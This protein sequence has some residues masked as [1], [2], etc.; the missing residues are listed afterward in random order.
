M[1]SVEITGWKVG[2]KKVACTQIVRAATGLGLADGKRVTD[3]V[4]DGEIQRI[5]V[6]SLED[7]NQLAKALIEIGAIASVSTTADDD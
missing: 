1:A 3:G 2:F 5:S 4:L 7:A 6:A